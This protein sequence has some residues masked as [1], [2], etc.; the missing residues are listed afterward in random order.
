MSNIMQ[1][2]VASVEL[3]WTSDDGQKQIFQ[4]N[5]T[6]G[7]KYKS[8]SGNWNTGESY[9]ITVTEKPSKNPK[10]GNE[11]WADI[12]G[13]GGAASP[14]AKPEN[15]NRSF[16]LSYAKDLFCSMATNLPGFAEKND[17]VV[18]VCGIADGLLN[19]LDGKP[20]QD[21]LPY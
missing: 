16:A 17:P 19:W 10:F 9:E 2:T 4:V 11:F 15:K 1:I 18:A 21:D 13:A 14:V 8:W 6:A 20:T 7:K 12:K 3:K 5:T